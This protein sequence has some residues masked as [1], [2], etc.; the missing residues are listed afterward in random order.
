M[1]EA[2]LCQATAV[3]VTWHSERYNQ[4]THGAGFLL[5]MFGATAMLLEVS[6]THD[7]W[8]MVSCVIYLLSL[9]ALYAASTLS[10]SFVAGPWRTF[11]RM[12][13]QVCIL[14]FIAGS[15]SAFVL[16]HWRTPT[17]WTILAT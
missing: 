9:T 8:R 15:F 7:E 13:D 5:S 1:S 6:R 3:P 10:H 2:P 16:T 17:G 4:W 12:V 11:Y 14:L